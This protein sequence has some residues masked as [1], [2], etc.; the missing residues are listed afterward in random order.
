MMNFSSCTISRQMKNG[1][2]INV[3]C[4]FLPRISSCPS[5]VILPV[6]SGCFNR[7]RS[8]YVR[9]RLVVSVPALNTSRT[10]VIKLSM[11]NSECLLCFS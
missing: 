11:V 4:Q 7:S 10:V 5:S 3:A 9:V 2:V 1:I 8:P 6:T